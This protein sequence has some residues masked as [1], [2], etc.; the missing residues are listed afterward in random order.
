MLDGLK[1]LALGAAAIGLAWA[2]R[3]GSRGKPVGLEPFEMAI[4]GRLSP[5]V[6]Q[7]LSLDPR[8]DGQYRIWVSLSWYLLAFGIVIMAVGLFGVLTHL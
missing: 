4:R 2:V 8:P 5:K 3:K 1:A 7:R 6:R